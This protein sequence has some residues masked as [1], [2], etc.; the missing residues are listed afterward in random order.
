MRRRIAWYCCYVATF[1]LS[2]GVSPAS[3]CTQDCPGAYCVG[4]CASEIEGSYMTCWFGCW[5]CLHYN[6]NT[7]DSPNPDT[8]DPR[9][10]CASASGTLCMSQD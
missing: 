6:C 2:L 4:A 8:C 5:A 10:L 7:Y 3:A 9:Y 1:V